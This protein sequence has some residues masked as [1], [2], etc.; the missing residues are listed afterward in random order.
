[1]QILSE[2]SP[3]HKILDKILV[4]L[5]DLS[6]HQKCRSAH[7]SWTQENTTLK[8]Q[9]KAFALKR[10][11]SFTSAPVH[12]PYILRSFMEVEYL[13]MPSRL[14]Y[15]Y[16]QNIVSNYTKN[17]PSGQFHYKQSISKILTITKVVQMHKLKMLKN[18]K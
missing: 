12:Y 4:Y 6:S 3:S 7:L 2:G 5:M 16:A 17:N 13:L 9:W 11:E 18:S 15:T 1:M 10:Q 14:Q 8:E